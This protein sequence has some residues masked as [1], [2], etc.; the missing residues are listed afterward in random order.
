MLCFPLPLPHASVRHTD[1][2]LALQARGVLAPPTCNLASYAPPRPSEPVLW[3]H[4]V[5]APACLRCQRMC[6][7]MYLC[8]SAVCAFSCIIATEQLGIVIVGRTCCF[9]RSLP[10]A[11]SWGLGPSCCSVLRSCL[12]SALQLLV[13]QLMLGGTYYCCRVGTRVGFGGALS[14]LGDT[15]TG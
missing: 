9:A 12:A 10:C 7:C 13:L 1:C 5:T 2:A 14:A 8:S 11:P 4:A 6:G 15:S 3:P